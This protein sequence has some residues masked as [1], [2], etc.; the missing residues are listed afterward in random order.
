MTIHVSRTLLQ[1]ATAD[2]VKWFRSGG[3][4]SQTFDVGDL[5]H[6]PEVAFDHLAPKLTLYFCEDTLSFNPLYTIII[7]LLVELNR[8]LGEACEAC[9]RSSVRTAARRV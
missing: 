4:R 5:A 2:H 7:I 1:Q 6:Y 3:N 8:R 9:C